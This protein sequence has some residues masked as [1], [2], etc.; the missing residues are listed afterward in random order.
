MTGNWRRAALWGG[1]TF[2]VMSGCATTPQMRFYTLE[3]AQPPVA[4]GASAV[5]RELTLAVG[6]VDLPEYLDRPQMVTRSGGNQ[7]QVHE[8]ER[9]G[10]LLQDEATAA[11]V[12]NLA[13]LLDTRRVHA[14]PSRVVTDYDY[15]I[16]VDVRMLDGELGGIVV[17]DAAWSVVDDTRGTK[18]STEFSRY[19][20]LAEGPGFDAYAAALSQ[21]LALLSK[22][23]AQRL[24]GQHRRGS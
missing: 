12:G 21:A 22:D 5:K 17:L 14:Y 2:A 9:W 10:G 7:L 23:I 4:T 16:A 1:L 3:A 24:P 6:P 15:R 20:V 19:E 13:R 18:L 11:L 8:F